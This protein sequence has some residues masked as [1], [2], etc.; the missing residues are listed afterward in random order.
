L[1]AAASGIGWL[2][3]IVG[4]VPDAQV[5]PIDFWLI[6]LYVFYSIATFPHFSVMIVLLLAMALGYLQFTITKKI[7]YWFAAAIAG[8]I[9]LPLQPFTVALGNLAAFGAIL[10][11]WRAKGRIRLKDLVPFFLIVAIQLPLLLYYQSLVATNPLWTEFA[12]QNVV[13]SPSPIYFLLGIGIIAPFAI[14][15]ALIAYRRKMILGVQSIFWSTSALLLS[16]A[17]TL[18]QRRFTLVIM[19]PLALLATVGLGYGLLPALRGTWPGWIRPR[20]G[21]LLALFVVLALPSTLYLATGGALYA[22]STPEN[23]YD[24]EPIHHAIDWLSETAVPSDAVLASEATGLLI[25]AFSGLRTYIGHP[26][27]TLHYENK[28]EL[29]GRFF[30]AH[31]MTSSEREELLRDCLCDWVLV[32]PYESIDAN[33]QLPEAL[34][35]RYE[36]DGVRIYQ[37]TGANENEATG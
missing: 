11:S 14:W 9:M 34:V 12:S 10:G 30:S 15:G 21:L 7:G 19:V 28:L 36:R 25:P 6:D 22:S 33:L 13:L 4:W 5:S 16:L 31:D 26:I 3:L 23:M 35:L 17:P 2:L 18:I 27:E 29:V 20:R 32:G 1:A 24:P 37:Q 8:L